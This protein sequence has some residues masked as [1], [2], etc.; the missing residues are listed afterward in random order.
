MKPDSS[1]P[2]PSAKSKQANGSDPAIAMQPRPKL[3]YA[4]LLAFVLWI[5]FLLTLYFTTV[6]HKT[7]VHVGSDAV[8]AQ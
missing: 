2:K 7:D 6:Y 5:G 4:L 3:F 1:A 8:Q